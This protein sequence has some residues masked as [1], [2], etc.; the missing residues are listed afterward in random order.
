MPTARCMAAAFVLGGR[1]VRPR[2]RR[3]RSR[4][5][6]RGHRPAATYRGHQE[7]DRGGVRERQGPPPSH[8]PA[9]LPGRIPLSSG[10]P[11]EVSGRGYAA[12]R[13]PGSTR[14]GSFAT[15]ATPPT[16]GRL[17]A[18]GP[19]SAPPKIA[20]SRP[21][22]RRC[23]GPETA[24]ADLD[25]PARRR[26]AAAVLSDLAVILADGGLLERNHP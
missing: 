26:R 10:H 14:P 2:H 1:V 3:R 24:A 23:S 17:R 12:G 5:R 19:R 7:V 22:A 9:P 16:P 20:A 8:P 15:T 11:P 18:T 6:L 4:C 13:R 25:H 21:R